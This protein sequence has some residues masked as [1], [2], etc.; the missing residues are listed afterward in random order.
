M[1][2][3]TSKSEKMMSIKEIA[4]MLGVSY[5][6]IKN[7]VKRLFPEAVKNGKRTLLNETQIACISKDIV[8]N[9]DV[10]KQINNNGKFMTIRNIA[11]AL[12]VS[13]DTINRCV[14]RIFPN[15]LQ[16]GKTA[17][18]DENEVACIS[19]ELKGNTAVLSHQTVE[20][21]ATVKNTTTEVEIIANYKQ[22][23]EALVSMLNMKNQEL[24]NENNNL[25]IELDE[26]KEWTT[27][28]KY[29]NNKGW[30][31]D[32]NKLSQLSKILGNLGY[33]RRKIYSVEYECGLWSYKIKDLDRYFLEPAF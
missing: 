30:E 10:Q 23:T 7:S 20:V 22:A 13:Y 21:S 16:H 8:N 24:Q 14:K 32:R 31:T 33:E 12:G 28:Q 18:F 25:K 15:K 5:D 2:E 19:K 9:T 26:S 1:N 17:Y 29:F 11:D 4:Q 27:L 6:T 3:V